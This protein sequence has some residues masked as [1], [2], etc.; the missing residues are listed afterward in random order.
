[1]HFRPD[2]PMHDR[3][4]VDHDFLSPSAGSEAITIAQTVNAFFR[5]EF[6]SCEMLVQGNTVLPD[7]LRQRLPGRRRHLTALLLPV[8]DEH[9]GQV[10]R[11]L[12][13]DPPARP[14]CTS[15]RRRGS[16]SPTIRIW[17]T[18][19]SC[20]TTSELADEHFEKEHY[21]EFCAAALPDI[22]EIV[23]DWVSSPEFETMLDDT[24]VATYPEHE[25]ERFRGHFRGLIDLW[26][27]DEAG[28]EPRRGHS[29]QLPRLGYTGSCATTKIRRKGSTVP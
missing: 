18:G 2:E 16:R 7:R 1:M 13:G 10:D 6:N 8:G 27:T 24:I 21:V 23:L 22:D 11:L 19:R 15:T 17:T 9:P 26:K 14:G 29:D 12:R 25:H 20:R 28:R 3:Y 4:A 5:W